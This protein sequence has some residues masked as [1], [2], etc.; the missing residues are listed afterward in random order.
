MQWHPDPPEWFKCFKTEETY[1]SP[2]PIEDFSSPG[3]LTS[4]TFVRGEK[5]PQ[6]IDKK[7]SLLQPQSE[8]APSVVGSQLSELSQS[9]AT[10]LDAML[11]CLVEPTDSDERERK[12]KF[13]EVG[14]KMERSTTRMHELLRN[15]RQHQAYEDLITI[16]EKTVADQIHTIEDVTNRMESARKAS[17]GENQ[18]TDM[19]S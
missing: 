14:K 18:R 8:I 1:L 2:P 11:E 10:S 12:A 6:S 15:Y 3:V 13:Q 16:M 17:S 9:L 4:C 7:S 19:E 5:I